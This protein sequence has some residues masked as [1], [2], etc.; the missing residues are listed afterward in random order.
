M[1]LFFFP[2]FLFY[3]NVNYQV[4]FCECSTRK[5]ELLLDILTLHS[6]SSDIWIHQEAG[7]F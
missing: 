4:Y 6:G 1:K 7:W 2:S 3:V 5:C